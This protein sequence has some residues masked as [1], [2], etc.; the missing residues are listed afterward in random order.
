[1]KVQ[2][3]RAAVILGGICVP[4]LAHAYCSEPRRYASSS[5]EGQVSDHIDY[6]LCLHNE[7]VDSLNEHARLI[8][9]LGGEIDGMRAD[10]AAGS[11]SAPTL[12]M[13]EDARTA[14]ACAA[15]INWTSHSR[16]RS[17]SAPSAIPRFSQK[18]VTS[19]CAV[20]PCA[21]L[22]R[23]ASRSSSVRRWRACIL[24]SLSALGGPSAAKPSLNWV[25]MLRKYSRTC[26]LI[27]S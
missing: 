7:Q 21:C 15:W 27:S 24:A 12:I 17:V 2:M 9:Q 25:S 4:G 18:A 16:L 6:L 20:P 19:P 1:M 13:R 22:V 3:F 5:F 10:G 11:E 26:C 8:N 23:N 14:V